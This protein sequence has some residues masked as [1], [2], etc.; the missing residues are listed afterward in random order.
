MNLDERAHRAARAVQ[1]SVEGV[2]PKP[3]PSGRVIAVRRAALALALLAVVGYLSIQVF[4]NLGNRRVKTA[5]E[6]KK[7]EQI[8]EPAEEG[9][10]D[11][12]SDSGPRS[13]GGGSRPSGGKAPEAG[14]GANSAGTISR[15]LEIAFNLGSPQGNG[16]IY[17][18]N[19]D[20]SNLREL[21][22]GSQP[23]WSPDGKLIAFIDHWKGGAIQSMNSDGSGLQNLGVRGNS[24]TWSP[25]AGQLAFNRECDA[26]FGGPC[27]LPD[28]SKKDCGP[29]CGIGVVARDGTGA[30]RLGN[31]IWPD[32]GP[33]GRIIFADGTPSG[34]C[35]RYRSGAWADPLGCTLPIWV[36]NPD[37]SGRTRL[38]IDKA[39]SPTWSHD[40]RRIAYYTETDGVFIA[41]S[42][43]TGI[44]KVAP[45]GYKEPSW[46]P[47][48]LWLALVRYTPDNWHSISLRSIDGSAEKRLTTGG[49]DNFPAFSPRR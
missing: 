42:D 35:S 15:D 26:Q 24:P 4:E 31:G 40:G 28:G 13:S 30:L 14:T 46:S 20:G 29:E 22:A 49:N 41:N 18:M 12:G 38:P 36:M 19:A 48:G 37:G 39:I 33:D 1:V 11:S 17:L 43:G 6:P 32:W 23:G 21:R 7:T 47:D 45:A 10:S 5:D 44:V 3:M 2:S 25:D 27:D 8:N 16:G 34:P 9:K